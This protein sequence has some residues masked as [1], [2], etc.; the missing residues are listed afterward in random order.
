[1]FTGSSIIDTVLR[2]LKVRVPTKTRVRW[3][4]RAKVKNSKNLH[5]LDG[6]I[7][8]VIWKEASVG[9][10]FKFMIAWDSHKRGETK[11]MTGDHRDFGLHMLGVYTNMIANETDYKPPSGSSL[12]ISR[13]VQIYSKQEHDWVALGVLFPHK[14]RIL[15]ADAVR[16]WLIP[17]PSIEEE[18]DCPPSVNYI[19]P[20]PPLERMPFN[21]LPSLPGMIHPMYNMTPGSHDKWNI[22]PIPGWTGIGEPEHIGLPPLVSPLNLADTLEFDDIE[23][24]TIRDFLE[25][26]KDIHVNGRHFIDTI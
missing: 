21:A 23:P 12:H 3:G 6:V 22:D 26:W 9:N 1:M 25:E 14:V 10:G 20:P 4:R 17:N 8:D 15:K 16:E 24:S 5:H 7:T 2:E 19:S 18:N 13:D 11:R